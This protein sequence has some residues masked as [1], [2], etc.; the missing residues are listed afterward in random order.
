M[1]GNKVIKSEHRFW[2]HHGVYLKTIEKLVVRTHTSAFT[3]AYFTNS[4]TSERIF[5]SHRYKLEF[6]RFYDVQPISI[7]SFTPV[8][9][10][11][12]HRVKYGEKTATPIELLLLSLQIAHEP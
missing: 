4:I 7:Q 1:Q 3:L 2:L 8:L 12:G 6:Y 5:Q 10:N 9:N 11:A